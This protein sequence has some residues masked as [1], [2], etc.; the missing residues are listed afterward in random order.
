MLCLSTAKEIQD[1]FWVGF[2][3][4][5]GTMLSWMC[6]SQNI[7]GVARFYTEKDQQSRCLKIQS[8]FWTR[9]VF[10]GAFHYQKTPTIFGAWVEFVFFNSR[11]LQCE[12]PS[13]P[14]FRDIFSNQWGER[15]VIQLWAWWGH[16]HLF[17]AQK[18][19]LWMVGLKYTWAAGFQFRWKE[20]HPSEAVRRELI[21]L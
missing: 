2:C 18:R 7:S 11:L 20:P 5:A 19:E 13:E 16:S 9:I 1:L 6:S 4:F 8:L 14:V 15:G 3:S 21:S 17:V 10:Q 12:L